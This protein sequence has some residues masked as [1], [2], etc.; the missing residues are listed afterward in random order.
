MANFTLDRGSAGV[1]G[2]CYTYPIHD[3]GSLPYE[4]Y[5][6]IPILKDDGL[7]NPDG[8][9]FWNL[10]EESRVGSRDSS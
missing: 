10:E 1:Y 4:D 8:V 5:L 2:T 9:G 7:Q 6:D 3:D